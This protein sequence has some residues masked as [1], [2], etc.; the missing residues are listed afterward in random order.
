VWGI[1]K[2]FGVKNAQAEGLAHL[3]EE[4][5]R[6]FL[7]GGRLAGGMLGA[8]ED[9][10]VAAAGAGE[11]NGEANGGEHEDDGRVRGELGEEVG[12]A[13]RA[14]GCLRALTAE[15]SGEIGGFALLEEDDADDEERD[16]N[17]EN[18]D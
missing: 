15:G 14:K 12:C 5:C 1:E 13:A 17:V 16:N 4:S 2:A 3:E 7:R 10:V 11:Q 9:G 8:R 18:N 6:L